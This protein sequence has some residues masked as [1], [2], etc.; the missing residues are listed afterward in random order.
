[1]D[2]ILLDRQFLALGQE[3][4]F[5]GGRGD[6]DVLG[7]CNGDIALGLASIWVAMALTS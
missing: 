3:V 2:M 5:I 4:I 7:G 6:G 1:M